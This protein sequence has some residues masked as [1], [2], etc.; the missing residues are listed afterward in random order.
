[1]PTER[2]GIDIGGVIT[3]GTKEDPDTFLRGNHLKNP[4]YSNSFESIGRLVRERFGS[5]TCLVS[6]CREATQKKTLEWLRHHKFYCITGINPDNVH[7]CIRR[8]EKSKIC[9]SLGITHF[10][11][12]KLEVLGYLHESGIRN[13]YLFNPN[14]REIDG[15]REHLKHVTIVS[16]W[17]E[18][19]DIL[20]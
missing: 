18:L 16:G 10:I 5:D 15:Y 20:L 8:K 6:K 7:F 2:L 3:C 4:R 17:A 13:L 14:E 1:M 9:K 12:D 11:D 19:S